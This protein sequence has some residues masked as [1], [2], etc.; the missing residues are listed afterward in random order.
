M[1]QSADGP[2]LYSAVLR[3]HRSLGRR[4]TTRIV[5]VVAGVWFV[6]GLAF[7]LMG[8]W[9]VLPFLGVE[10]LLLLVLFRLNLRAGNACEAINLTP[11]ALT[12]R[13]TDHWGQQSL[14]SFPPQWLQVNLE[15]LAGRDNR[16]ELRSH[17][18]SLTIASFLPAHERAEL[19]L[20]LRR[21]LA[22]L[23]GSGD[24]LAAS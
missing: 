14:V 6:V 11:R 19:A 8:A 13:R 20:A 2:V 21:A 5:L 3:P 18:R 4:G 16:L 15:P 24:G 1:N 23:H 9:P 12:V 7:G 17:G 10:V 22:R